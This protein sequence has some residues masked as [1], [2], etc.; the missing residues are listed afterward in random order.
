MLDQI[1]G[2]CLVERNMETSKHGERC[3]YE[4]V[5]KWKTIV[6]LIF[7]KQYNTHAPGCTRHPFQILFTRRKKFFIDN[8]W[9][10][11]RGI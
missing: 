6:W 9:Y 5:K 11:L 2:S 4:L 7:E 3:C 8:E 10:M 1:Y